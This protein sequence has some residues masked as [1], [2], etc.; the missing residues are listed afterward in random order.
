MKIL[1]FADTHFSQYSSIIRR[2][3]NKYSARLE[4]L[5]ESLNWVIDSANKYN[6]DKVI[7]L[8]DFFDKP[9][10]DS[11][12]ITALKE[13]KWD[14]L[15]APISFIVG[16]HETA[17]ADLSYN[18]VEALRKYGEIISTPKQETVDNANL[19]Y[20]PYQFRCETPLSDI[21]SQYHR[22]GTTYIF[23]HNDIA[24]IQY[25]AYK[26]VNGFSIE[27]IHNSCDFYI[28]GH[29]H[30]GCFVDD[31]H[32]I[33]NL[34]NLTGQN[35]SEDAYRYNHDIV[36]ID[37]DNKSFTFVE[38]PYAFNFYKIDLSHSGESL[39]TIFGK[40][41]N[42]SILSIKASENNVNQIRNMLNDYP[43]IVEYRV[44][45]EM[46]GQKDD[47]PTFQ[48]VMNIDHIKQFQEYIFSNMG[49]SPIIVEEVNNLNVN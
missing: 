12:E 21:V 13:I 24:G 2:R 27:D 7:C 15:D 44:T 4:N 19:I 48:E 35:F 3:G 5:I 28:N 10:L 25:G 33:L 46:C 45:I 40:L 30:N 38:N 42:N 32:R 39:E 29:L 26:S 9:T 37:T 23:S 41:K 47:S 18:S 16:N 8:G 34:G 31:E 36:I 1:C 14:N 20:I 17:S 6:V 49:T 11:E 22:T 43:N